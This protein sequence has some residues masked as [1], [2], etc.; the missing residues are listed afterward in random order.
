MSHSAARLLL[1]A[2][3]HAA[4]SGRVALWNLE[5]GERL[6]TLGQEYDAVLAAAAVRNAV[7]EWRATHG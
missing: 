2:G 1:A 6:A 3:G 7:A 4:K 5:T